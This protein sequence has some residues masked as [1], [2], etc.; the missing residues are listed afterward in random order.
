MIAKMPFGKTGH[1]STRTI[2]GSVSLGRVS[3][4]EADRALDL[5]FEFGVNHIDTAPKYG[6]AELRLG[7]WMKK[8]RDQFFLATKTNERTYQQAKEQ[9]EKSLDRLQVDRVDL[10]QYHNLTDVVE[11]EI[12]MGP[13]GALKFLVEAKDKGLTKF[14]GITGHGLHTPRFHRQ[15]LERFAFDSVL[16]PCNYLLLQ[17][18]TYADEFE[19]L[20]S[21]C[22]E[23]QIAVQTIKSIARG[24]WG[25]K[26]WSRSTWYEPLTD[27]EAIVK[28]V[29]WVL[30]IPGIFLNT[31]GDLQELPK[32]LKAAASFERRPSDEEM[33]KV[34]EDMQME[35]LFT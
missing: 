17:D 23:R 11:R 18:R 1:Q 19:K 3:Q 35:T 20:V 29:H 6:E 22:R 4:S 2:F 32:V 9:F 24:Y 8:Y 25:N 10:L 15:T 5:L 33:N 13:S 31:V 21:Y 16:L 27:E 26:E 30:G 12:I 28:C 14:I 7:P 34:I